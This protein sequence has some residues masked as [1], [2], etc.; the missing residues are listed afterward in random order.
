LGHGV[1]PFQLDSEALESVTLACG[2]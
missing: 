2:T 1:L